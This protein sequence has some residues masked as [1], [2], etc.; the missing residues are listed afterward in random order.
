MEKR[1]GRAGRAGWG[2]GPAQGLQRDGRHLRAGGRV[3]GSFSR[4]WQDPPCWDDESFLHISWGIPVQAFTVASQSH[5]YVIL[6]QFHTQ[7]SSTV[8]CA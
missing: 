3:S 1:D 8:R 7:R 4:M 5:D 2:S 6:V